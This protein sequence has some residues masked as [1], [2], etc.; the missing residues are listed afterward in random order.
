M[1]GLH[2]QATSPAGS[3]K[4]TYHPSQEGSLQKGKGA[5]EC[6]AR[7]TWGACVRCPGKGLA[8]PGSHVFLRPD[9]DLSSICVR[10]HVWG[11]WVR[12][13]HPATQTQMGQRTEEEGGRGKVE[14][15]PGIGGPVS[16]TTSPVLKAA[17]S[18]PDAPRAR[19]VSRVPLHRTLPHGGS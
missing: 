13:G 11:E 14:V 5:A 1:L 6:R 17:M 18:C 4:T 16:P 8:F 10:I 15:S 19:S 7:P 3:K 2:T 9:G 12:A